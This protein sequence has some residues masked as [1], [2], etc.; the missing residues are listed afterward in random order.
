MWEQIIS[1]PKRFTAGLVS[2]Y[3]NEAKAPEMTERLVNLE[4]SSATNV[5]FPTEA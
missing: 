1:L 3:K 4:H 2:F 5:L